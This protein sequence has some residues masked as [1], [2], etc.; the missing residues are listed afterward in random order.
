MKNKIIEIINSFLEKA[1]RN[2]TNIQFVTNPTYID[3]KKA[4]SE[5][6]TSQKIYIAI[7]CFVP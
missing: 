4:F 3:K 2:Q 1:S 7:E 5:E 6:K